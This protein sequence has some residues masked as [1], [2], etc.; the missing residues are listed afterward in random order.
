MK[1]L[2]NEYFD[3]LLEIIILLIFLGP[4]IKLTVQFLSISV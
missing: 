3:V 4:L 1:D 2:L